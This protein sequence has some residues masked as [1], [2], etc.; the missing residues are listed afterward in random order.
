M[1]PLVI[2][3]REPTPFQIE[4]RSLGLIL[5]INVQ[6]QYGLAL[7]QIHSG[8]LPIGALNLFIVSIQIFPQLVQFLWYRYQHQMVILEFDF[9]TIGLEESCH[10]M[11]NESLNRL[12]DSG[13][14][15]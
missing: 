14:M 13:H 8:L 11:S 4:N 5:E 2:S 10:Q 15:K 1:L 9:Q 12:Y 7:I 6:G 3:G